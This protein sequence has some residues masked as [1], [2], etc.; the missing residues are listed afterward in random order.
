MWELYAMWVWIPIMLKLSYESF[1]PSS[2]A[3]VFFSLATFG[4]FAIGA[5]G[6]TLGGKLADK[7]GRTKF[8]IYMLSISGISSILIGFFFWNPWLL[9]I[10]ALIWGITILPDSAQYSAM[11]TEM[12]DTDLMGTA[13]TLQTAIGFLVAAISIIIMPFLVDT[14]SWQYAFSFLAIGPILGII[15]LVRLRNLPDS[16]KIAGGKR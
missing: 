5:F 16:K 3:T 1:Y 8:N 10:I 6:S 13:L 4:I 2:D 9:V 12:A 11:I 14:F 7:Y 15:S